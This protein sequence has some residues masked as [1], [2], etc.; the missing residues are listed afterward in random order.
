MAEKVKKPKSKA[1]KIIEWILF[2]VFGLLA[3]FVLAANI[4]SMIHKKENYGQAIRF[5]MGTF[6]I[7]TSSM[8]PDIAQGTMIITF[9]EDISKFEERLNN[10][11]TIDVTLAN[12]QVETDYVPDPAKY[13]DRISTNQVMTHRLREIH[14]NKDVEFGKGRYVFITTGINTKG[15]YSLEGQY[16]LFT[17]SQYLGTVKVVSSFLGGFMSFISSA[18]GLIC[19]LLVPAGYLIVVSS[20]DI[21]K[22]LKE[23]EE[24][25]AQPREKLDGDHLSKISDE[26][27]E[28]LKNELLE[29]MIKAKKEGKK[30][31]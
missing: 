28:R 24:E 19:I 29:E 22:A 8:E 5:G 31:D 9:K 20:M 21:F 26:D 10:N 1:R 3:G 6:V 30:N 2:G 14:E 17:E 27:R 18:L 12:I 7:L 15:E 11:E 25:Q 23:S 16:Q 4:S 13:R